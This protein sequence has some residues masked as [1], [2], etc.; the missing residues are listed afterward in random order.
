M[1]SIYRA[2][3]PEPVGS[4]TSSVVLTSNPTYLHVLTLTGV[5]AGARREG[6]EHGPGVG[7]GRGARGEGAQGETHEKGPRPVPAR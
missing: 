5:Q 7:D 4:G 3:T 1:N 2:Q 6:Y